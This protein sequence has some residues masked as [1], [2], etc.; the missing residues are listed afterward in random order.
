[1]SDEVV[2]KVVGGKQSLLDLV[3]EAQL[4]DGHQDRPGIGHF[5]KV[6]SASLGEF[7]RREYRGKV[8]LLRK[9]PT[10]RWPSR[11]LRRGSSSPPPCTP[12]PSHRLRACSWKAEHS[13]RKDTWQRDFKF[14]WREKR[15]FSFVP[16]AASCHF[17]F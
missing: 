1:M 16:E 15:T 6:F 7:L 2:S 8:L 5:T 14:D 17:A 12:A 3:V 13:R 11:P 4:A 9:Q 10:C